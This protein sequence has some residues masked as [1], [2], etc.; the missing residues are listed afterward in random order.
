MFYDANMPLSYRSMFYD[1]NMPLISF[2]LFYYPS[3]ESCYCTPSANCKGS[4]PCS[5]YV[6]LVGCMV[7]ASTAC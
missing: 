4:G 3:N 6:S 7:E 2:F 5:S 1:A